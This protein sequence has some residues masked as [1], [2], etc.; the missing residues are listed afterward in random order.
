MW[1]SS[2]R[3]GILGWTLPVK[4]NGFRLAMLASVNVTLPLGVVIESTAV[5]NDFLT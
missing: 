3:Y 2:C 4:A 1:D 5:L